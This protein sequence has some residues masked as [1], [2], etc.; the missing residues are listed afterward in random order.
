MTGLSAMDPSIE[1]D[2]EA[3]IQ[4][5]YMAP[6]GLL[7]A[8]IDGEILMVNPLCA[9]LLMPLSP[10]G[11]LSNLYTALEGLAP[12][13]RSRVQAYPESH[14]MVFEGLQLRVP[15]DPRHRTDSRILALTLLKLDGQRVMAVLGDV[16]QSVQR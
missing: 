9:Q 15:A 16:T 11:G 5:L 1:D 2:Y 6:I 7:Q 4:F 10:D 13:L 14:G 8:R 3:L 12:D